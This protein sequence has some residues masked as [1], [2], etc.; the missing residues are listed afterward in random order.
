[1][2][3][4][5]ERWHA[6]CQSL[7]RWIETHNGSLPKQGDK[8]PCG[9]EIGAWL[10]FQRMRLKSQ[11]LEGIRI[12][13][14]DDAAPCWR[15]TVVLSLESL[16]K[17]PNITELKRESQFTASLTVAAALVAELGRL[18]RNSGTSSNEDLVAGWIANQRRHALRGTLSIERAQRL[19]R[20]LPGWSLEGMPDEGSR[21]WQKSLASLVARVKELG[22]LPTGPSAEWMRKQ[23]RALELGKLLEGRER[24]LNE[25]LPGW[26]RLSRRRESM[27]RTAG[28]ESTSLPAVSEQAG[29]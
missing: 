6:R 27:K 2:C 3:V 22:R 20:T 5:Q 9:F 15:S 29:I 16:H 21:R 18:P 28:Y 24:A 19:D 4:L 7:R 17:F 25:A 11:R 10:N 1:M 14:L 13:A 12:G 26:N 8:L 23:R